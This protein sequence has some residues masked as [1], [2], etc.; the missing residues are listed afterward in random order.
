MFLEHVITQH[1]HIA[2]QEWVCIACSAAVSV[3]AAR[4]AFGRRAR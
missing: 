1:H 4:P 3:P 2:G